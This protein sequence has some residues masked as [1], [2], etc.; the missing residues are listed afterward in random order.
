MN[1]LT[2]SPPRALELI[3][4]AYTY[5]QK[6][7]APNTLRAYDSLW[8]EFCYFADRMRANALPASPGLVVA[9][10]SELADKQAMSTLSG[11]LSAIRHYHEQA[12]LPDPTRDASVR[13]VLEGIKREHGKPP[14]RKK[15]I[16]RDILKALLRV[17]PQTIRGARNRAMLLTGYA[18]DLRRAEIVALNVRNVEFL[19]DRMIVTIAHS[20]TDQRGA[21]YAI[22][23][24]RVTNKSICA[25]HA[26]ELW[27]RIGVVTSGAIFR[28]VDRWENVGVK[29]LTAQ[30]VKDI[31]KAAAKANGYDPDIFGAHGLRRGLIT[32]AARNQDTSLDIRKVSRHKQEIMLDVYNEEAAAA[33]MRVIG[34][35]L[36]E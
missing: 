34:R 19:D 14:A 21:G 33:Q 10:I 9:H 7:K 16:D 17:Q 12:R 22:N 2:S 31:V 6:S 1:E 5:A 11:R 4:R 8:R 35:A 3:E 32:Q 20:K 36:T 25:V 27:L 15:A 24:P 26:L 30:V 28:E 13:A 23:V 18:C 29:A